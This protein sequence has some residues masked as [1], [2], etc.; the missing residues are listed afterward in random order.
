VPRIYKAAL[1]TFRGL[2]HAGRTEAAV[3]EELIVL[4]V[5][6]PAGV[7][8]APNP[9]WYVAMIGSLLAILAIELLNTA[10][11]KLCDHVSPEW[12]TNIGLV[13]DYGS[14]AVF[15]GLCLAGLVWIVAIATRFGF[16]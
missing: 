4:A 5:A 12:R 6:L 3:R 11:E 15:F 8:L 1:N 7:W 10:I 16:L 14:A 9:A 13:K 2:A